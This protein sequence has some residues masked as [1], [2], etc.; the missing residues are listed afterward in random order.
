LHKVHLNA[1]HTIEQTYLYISC[2]EADVSTSTYITVVIHH[3]KGDV[4]LATVT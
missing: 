4:C 2:T 1:V 3:L